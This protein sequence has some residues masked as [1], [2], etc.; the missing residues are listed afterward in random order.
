[1]TAVVTGK[2]TRATWLTGASGLL[3]L[4]AAVVMMVVAPPSAAHPSPPRAPAQT[5]TE[6]AAYTRATHP[7]LP[8]RLA[9]PASPRP[10]RAQR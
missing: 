2:R 4:V 5:V 1:M 9:A 3:I 7:G 6:S 8:P 10:N